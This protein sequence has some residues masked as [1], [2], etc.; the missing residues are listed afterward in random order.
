MIITTCGN[1]IP[2]AKALAR[3]LH[4]LYSPVTISQFPDGD[5]YLK[6]NTAV[7]G[8]KVVIVH[9]FQPH[10]NQSLLNLIVA[11][12][13]ARDLGAQKII[14]VAPYLAYMRQDTRF[15]PGEAISSRIMAKHLNLCIDK[16][17]TID[18]HLHRYKSLRDI[19]T[20]P[21]VK[22]TANTL[23]ADYIKT[24]VKN[25][26]IIGPDGE[27]FQWADDIARHIHVQATVLKK[28]RY[29]S[30]HVQVKMIK[31][32]SLRGKNV[33]I[34]DDIISTGH[35]IAEAAKQARAMGAKSITAIGVH[36]LLVE[37]AMAK[38]RR[39]GVNKI[40]TT[41]CIQHPTN[42]IDITPLLAKELKKEL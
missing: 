16:I 8:K 18:P 20:I 41:N 36:G 2:I 21:A 12:E 1:S 33:V 42:R 6:Y 11:A 23:I 25:E 39:A 17:I 22:L 29:S 34:V 28:T 27:S 37:K 31:P 7:K 35:T 15:H 9:S 38:L 26:V 13:T 14:L 10:S 40:I 19:F 30:R 3:K 32:I 5:I 4:A 24:H